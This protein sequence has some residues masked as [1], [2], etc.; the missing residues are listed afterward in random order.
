M[1]KLEIKKN[2]YSDAENCPVRL[3]L[4]RIGEK[5]SILILQIIKENEVM[6][7]S[8]IDR[9]I[10]DI[11]QK[12]LSKTLRSLEIDGLIER[13]IYPVIP[14]KVEYRLTSLGE[15]LFPHIAGISN[16]ALKN[17][18][19]IIENRKNFELRKNTN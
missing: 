4:D 7:F 16:W 9:T 11:S 19:T 2:K 5:W 10:G 14:P 12:M 3:V 18:A 6:R 1:N 8:E 17:L 15:D 13:K